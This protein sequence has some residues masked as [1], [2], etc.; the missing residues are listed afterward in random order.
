MEVDLGFKEITVRLA[1]RP[2]LE[3]GASVRLAIPAHA[4]H[5]FDADSGAR[6]N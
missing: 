1:G 3:L 6:L 2:T 5:L 4:V